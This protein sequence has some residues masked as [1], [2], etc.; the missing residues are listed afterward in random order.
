M[1]AIAGRGI[2]AYLHLTVTPARDGRF[3]NEQV[4]T[5]KRPLSYQIFLPGAVFSS[6]SQEVVQTYTVVSSA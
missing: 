5:V 1:R 4:Q 6:R 2:L 3:R